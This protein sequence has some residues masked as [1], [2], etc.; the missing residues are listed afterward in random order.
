MLVDNFTS[1][2]KNNMW[3]GFIKLCLH[4]KITP[5]KLYCPKLVSSSNIY[6][7]PQTVIPVLFPSSFW[8]NNSTMLLKHI[9][10]ILKLAVT[11]IIIINVLLCIASVLPNQYKQKNKMLIDFDYM[12]SQLY[13]QHCTFVE[14]GEGVC[15][16]SY[17]QCFLVLINTIWYIFNSNVY[18]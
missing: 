8:I 11:R 18:L 16:V 7:F 2:Q 5:I 14:I 13:V 12:V 15:S 9:Q 10:N 17:V 1:K 4:N 6:I 3:V